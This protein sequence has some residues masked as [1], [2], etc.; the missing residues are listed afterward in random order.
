MCKKKALDNNFQL[1]GVLDHLVNQIVRRYRLILLALGV[2]ALE[3]EE[4]IAGQVPLALF[5]F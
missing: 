1:L 2:L 3:V 5:F 4:V